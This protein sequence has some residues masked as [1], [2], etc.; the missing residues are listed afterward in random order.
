[1]RHRWPFRLLRIFVAIVDKRLA[2][3]IK[4]LLKIAVFLDFEIVVGFALILLSFRQD[5]QNETSSVQRNALHNL[6]SVK[7][8]VTHYLLTSLDQTPLLN[9][10]CF[11]NI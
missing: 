6:K 4:N 3:N 11:T 7:V 8:L 2:N 9:A 1:M 5:F 10:G